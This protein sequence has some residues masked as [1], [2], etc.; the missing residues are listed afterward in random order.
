[1]GEAFKPTAL[2]STAVLCYGRAIPPWPAS[3][4]APIRTSWQHE[5][6]NLMATGFS[7]SWEAGRDRRAHEGPF[8]GLMPGF[9]ARIRDA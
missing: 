6:E 1:M 5:A 8:L 7:A 4:L 3:L 9:H 2:R